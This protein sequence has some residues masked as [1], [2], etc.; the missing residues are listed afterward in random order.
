M[1]P[2]TGNTV[3]FVNPEVTMDMHPSN[4]TSW[5]NYH[6]ELVKIDVDRGAWVLWWK[7]LGVL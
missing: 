4:K 2:P 3:E 6:A 1:A 7:S 5:L